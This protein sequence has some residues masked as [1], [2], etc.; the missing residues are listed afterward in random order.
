MPHGPP[1][2]TSK[3]HDF[4]GRVLHPVNPGHPGHRIK[5]AAPGLSDISIPIFS[6][7]P[8]SRVRQAANHQKLALFARMEVPVIPFAASIPKERAGPALLPNLTFLPG[9]RW[10]FA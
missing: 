5:G 6:R 8:D 1:N 9:P 4:D 2:A 10:M 3:N 7:D